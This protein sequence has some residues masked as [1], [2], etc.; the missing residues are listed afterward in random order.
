MNSLMNSSQHSIDLLNLSLPS[1]GLD[2]MLLK[3]TFILCLKYEYTD[4]MRLLRIL[5]G[6]MLTF[7][8][9][10]PTHFQTTVL[11]TLWTSDNALAALPKTGELNIECKTKNLK[12]DMNPIPLEDTQ[13]LNQRHNTQ[14]EK[15][16]T[17][18][19]YKS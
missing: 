2:V 18:R 6:L 4:S 15:V 7:P 8:L 16:L 3:N 5:S 14:H 13:A 10:F 11:E 19:M 12:I 1:R 9:S 17:E